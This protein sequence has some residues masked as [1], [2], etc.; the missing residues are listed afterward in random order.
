M[1]WLEYERKKR[2]LTDQGLSSQ[3]YEIELQ[4]L[5]REMEGGGIAE[6]REEGSDGGAR[7]TRDF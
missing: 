6:Q 4:R 5:L 3:Q 1:D 2:K 7:G